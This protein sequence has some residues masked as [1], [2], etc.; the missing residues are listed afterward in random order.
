MLIYL[1]ISILNSF[2]FNLYAGINKLT[3]F[4]VKIQH[5][6]FKFQININLQLIE[7]HCIEKAHLE[8]N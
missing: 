2:F 1:N 5:S 7:P 6:I 8:A 4:R 3:Y